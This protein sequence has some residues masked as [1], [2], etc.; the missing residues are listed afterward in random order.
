LKTPGGSFDIAAKQSE[1]IELEERVSVPDLWEDPDEARRVNRRLASLEKTIGRVEAIETA[2]SDADVLLE[3]GEAESDADSVAEAAAGLTQ[4]EVDLGELERETLFFGEYDDSKALVS[5][6]A[7][8]GGVDAQDWA[9]IL[10]RMYT[11]YLSAA[12]F[13]VTVEEVQPG[14]EAGIKSASF[15]VDGEH[16]YGT[17]EGERG[18]H[19]LVRI[20]PFDSAARRHTSFAAVDV[21][22]EVE[23]A[24][25]E[26]NEEDLKVDTFRAQGAGGQHVNTTDSAVRITHTPTGIVVSCQAE[27]SQIQ[28]RARAMEMLQSRLADLARQQHADRLEEI[29]GEQSEAA[30]G[31]QI[32]S[33]VMQPYQLVKDLRTDVEIGNVQ[34]VLDGSI[35]PFIDAYLEWRRR[36]QE[37]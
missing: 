9:E 33:Y 24:L 2:L 34:G 26:I 11:R 23:T 27:R 35:A 17:M 16:P 28:N 1:L 12:G 14:D 4:V 29:R 21:I 37:G 15:T 3:L 20:S 25:F 6:H 22:P 31:H 30:W 18:V 13:E 5:V 7:G 10:L 19:R 32:R 36:G 8:A